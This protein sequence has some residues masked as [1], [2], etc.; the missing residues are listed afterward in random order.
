MKV[1]IRG[2]F[3]LKKI[4]HK[5]KF[6]RRGYSWATISCAAPTRMLPQSQ[7]TQTKEV[8]G[9]IGNALIILAIGISD[10]GQ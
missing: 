9:F 2:I 1:F 8:C 5:L 3:I 6:G 10:L 7:R 4:I